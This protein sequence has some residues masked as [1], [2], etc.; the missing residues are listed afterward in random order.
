M[1]G[2]YIHIPFC[3]QKCRYCDFPSYAG[4]EGRMAAYLSALMRELEARAA[5]LSAMGEDV[6]FDTVFFG[7]G[8]PSL[9]S[10]DAIGTLLRQA[11]ELFA[12]P[13]SAE[14]TMECNPG[15]VTAESLKTYREAG[16]NRLSMGFQSAD[17]GLLRRIGRIH[18]RAQFEEAF[19][20]ARHTGFTNIN[21][22]VMH[23]LPGQKE[24]DYLD[25]L[26]YII[27]LGP[28][29]I[30]AYALIL[31]ENTP[32]YHDVAAGRESL[33]DEDDTAAMQD[34]GMAVLA[35][36]GYTR[37]E[38][39]NFA[40]P[41]FECRHNINYWENGP[42]LGLGAAA[43]S[44]WWVDGAWCRFANP[45]ELDAYERTAVQPP[46]LEIIPKKEEMF[47]SVMLG[48]R[49]VRG[50]DKDRFRARY[51]V[52]PWEVFPEA[53]KQLRTRGWLME[54]SQFLRLSETGLDFQNSALELF[55]E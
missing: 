37:Y 43:H 12:I 18:T 4:A 26:R 28:E 47:E 34:A 15:T 53:I 46:E 32:L 55:M 8:T 41:G 9:L 24:A 23:G 54:D 30:S 17:D 1:A 35:E 45:S 33:P 20:A 49:M 50:L 52:S 44:A 11:R 22:D 36:R 40:K 29:H 39:S 21:V 7:G 27:G 5:W 14:I 6:A 42:Y 2:L 31:E 13:A 10:P 48:L 19:S 3:K 16:V 25:T 51:G 38:I